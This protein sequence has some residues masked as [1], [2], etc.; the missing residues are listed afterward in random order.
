M[1]P[2]KLHSTLCRDESGVYISA[3]ASSPRHLPDDI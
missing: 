1:A 3:V 2:S